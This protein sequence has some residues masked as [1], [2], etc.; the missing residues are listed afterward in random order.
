MRGSSN[1]PQV[2]RIMG[3]GFT[4]TPKVCKTIA[5]NH[6]NNSHKGQDFTYFWSLGRED[7]EALGGQT[8]LPHSEFTGLLLRNLN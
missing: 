8:T 6:Q 4:W 1:Q 3:L 7:G 2:A 5:L